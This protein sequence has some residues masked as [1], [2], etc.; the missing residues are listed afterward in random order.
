MIAAWYKSSPL[1]GPELLF[2]V[3][4][5]HASKLHYYAHIGDIESIRGLL[6]SGEALLHD[7]HPETGTN[8]L[9]VSSALGTFSHF[10]Y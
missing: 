3:P 2:R 9:A 7:L 8:A 4:R 5:V 10:T 6:S 1:S